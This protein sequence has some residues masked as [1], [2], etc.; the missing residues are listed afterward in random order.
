MAR[1][2]GHMQDYWIVRNSWGEGWGMEGFMYLERFG[3]G[4]EPCGM[5]KR[6][7]DG[8]ACKGDTK[9]VKY[10]GKCAVLSSSSYPTGVTKA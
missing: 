3:E 6:P 8:D 7:G 2:L 1:L 5:D 10:C 9:P 4:K